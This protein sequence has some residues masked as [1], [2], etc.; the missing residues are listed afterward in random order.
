M[1]SGTAKRGKVLQ[2]V[3]DAQSAI[4]PPAIDQRSAPRKPFAKAMNVEAECKSLSERRCSL[5]LRAFGNFQ[6]A[7]SARRRG[8][9]RP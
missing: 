2:A 3:T 4:A 5:V 7:G 6:D 1:S 9:G 8:T